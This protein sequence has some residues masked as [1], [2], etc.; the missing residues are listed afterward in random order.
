MFCCQI[1]IWKLSGLDDHK[2]N[3]RVWRH[4]M[5]TDPRPQNTFWSFFFNTLFVCVS[6]NRSQ[7]LTIFSN[8]VQTFLANPSSSFSQRTPLFAPSWRGRVSPKVV[9]LGSQWR[10][11]NGIPL[12]PFK[13]CRSHFYKNVKPIRNCLAHLVLC[14]LSL[15]KMCF[16]WLSRV[17]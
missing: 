1:S 7:G 14:L 3:T 6:F 12:F 9:A 8:S 2:S 10:F 5:R 17:D 11:L 13:Y 16:R 15:R 4:E